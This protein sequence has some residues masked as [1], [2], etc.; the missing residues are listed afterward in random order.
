MSDAE[1]KVAV[2]PVDGECPDVA[3]PLKR[4][5]ESVGAWERSL[6]FSR[7]SLGASFTPECLL[8]TPCARCYVFVCYVLQV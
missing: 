1:A 3:R 6:T 8:G 4:H 7:L 2:D 5:L